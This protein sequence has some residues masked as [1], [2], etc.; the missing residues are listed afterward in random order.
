ML[1]EKER[2][3]F[4]RLNVYHL[5]KYRLV[6]QEEWQMA[7]AYIS[8]ISAGGVCLRAGEKIAKDSILQ[9]S[10]NF[11]Q[12]S[13]PVFCSAKVVWVKKIGKANRFE[14]GLEFFKIE[15][16]LRQEIAQRVDYVRRRSE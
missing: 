16:L 10:I 14:M 13:S 15:D 6:S 3:K 12:L 1:E 2:R 9:V 5:V 8:D 7:I 4:V 11:P